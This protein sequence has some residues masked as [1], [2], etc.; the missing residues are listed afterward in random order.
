MLVQLLNLTFHINTKDQ[1]FYMVY[2]ESKI[3]GN[4]L[5]IFLYFINLKKKCKF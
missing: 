4:N 5:Y 2:R 1:Q 3:Y